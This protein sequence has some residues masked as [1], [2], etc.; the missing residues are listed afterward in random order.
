MNPTELERQADALDAYLH[1]AAEENIPDLPLEEADLAQSIRQ[2]VS[3]WIP[4]RQFSNQLAEQLIAKNK[5]A[6]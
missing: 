2:S 4:D 3:N 6:N 1:S 5:H